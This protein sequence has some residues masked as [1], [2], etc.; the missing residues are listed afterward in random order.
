MIF[1]KI[2]KKIHEK[3]TVN[4][5]LYMVVSN[6]TE[7]TTSNFNTLEEHKKILSNCFFFLFQ[8]NYSEVRAVTCSESQL[9]FV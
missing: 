5:T 9:L 8:L 3:V 2:R 1:K 7:N 4:T 6:Y